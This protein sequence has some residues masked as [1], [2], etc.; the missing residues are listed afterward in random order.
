MR[1]RQ[2]GDWHLWERSVVVCRQALRRTVVGVLRRDRLASLLVVLLIGTVLLG[3]PTF[4][5][6]LE[7]AR[8]EAYHQLS[9]SLRRWL[10]SDCVRLGPLCE[11][12]DR[13][14]REVLGCLV[15]P[16]TCGGSEESPKAPVPVSCPDGLGPATGGPCGGS[17]EVPGLMS[18]REGFVN[19]RGRCVPAIEPGI[20][21]RAKFALE[22]Y[23]ECLQHACEAAGGKWVDSATIPG[24]KYPEG[25]T[26]G[27]TAAITTAFII[28]S[29]ECWWRL[30]ASPLGAIID[31][32]FD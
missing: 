19:S 30:V 12:V 29:Q 26:D 13:K 22:E 15:K 17:E 25:A 14:V 6:S 3:T 20:A 32:V 10:E 8:V 5:G 4:G 11:D 7:E 9:E 27:E 24:C 28:Y 23:D 18:C 16:E 1:I 31:R 21:Y 2:A